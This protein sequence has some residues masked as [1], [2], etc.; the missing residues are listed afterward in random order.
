MIT[1]VEQ[2]RIL[3]AENISRNKKETAKNDQYISEHKKMH[4]EYTKQFSA[5]PDAENMKYGEDPV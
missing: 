2:A 4:K 5:Y 1:A 3:Y